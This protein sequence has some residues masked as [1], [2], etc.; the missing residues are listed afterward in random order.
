MR[1]GDSLEWV[2]LRYDGNDCVSLDEIGE[3][4][5]PSSRRLASECS[6]PFS[7]VDP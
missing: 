4:G 6:N 1:V 7:S 3:L 2:D 5:D